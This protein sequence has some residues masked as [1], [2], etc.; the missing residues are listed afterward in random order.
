[1]TFRLSDD[2]EAVGEI[3]DQLLTALKDRNPA[4]SLAKLD[5]LWARLGVHIRAEHLH[6]FPAVI[7]RL[8]EA[9][10]VVDGLRS[11]HDFFMRE[12]ARAISILRD[13]ST[14]VTR[15]V[16]V[17]DAVRAVGKRLVTHNEIEE[18]T[19]YPW[20]ASLLTEPEQVEL[21]TRINRELE[22][23]PPRFS[24]ETWINQ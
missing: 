8:D 23:R 14:D 11:D 3:F 2:H 22:N 12:L 1:M 7:T 17:D 24:L 6:L 18:T 10:S 13:D 21:I 20:C 16:V 5:L 9:Q 4:L 19:I 15:W